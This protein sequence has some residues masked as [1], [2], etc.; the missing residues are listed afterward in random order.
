[1]VE[2]EIVDIVKAERH[3]EL[4]AVSADGW[5]SLSECL[6]KASEAGGKEQGNTFHQTKDETKN[7]S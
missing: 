6:W 4:K 2:M 7:S 1:M 3:H 5:R